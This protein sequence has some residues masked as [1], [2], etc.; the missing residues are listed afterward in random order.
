MIRQSTHVLAALVT[1]LLAAPGCV[2]P[3]QPEAPGAMLR[4]GPAPATIAPGMTAEQVRAAWGAPGDVWRSVGAYGAA[5]TWW[6]YGR[7]VWGQ[8][9][10]SAGVV[11]TVRFDGGIVATVDGVGI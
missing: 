11:A 9:S 2:V 5:E 10:R 6:Y 4:G 7:G 1:A 8:Q 3:H